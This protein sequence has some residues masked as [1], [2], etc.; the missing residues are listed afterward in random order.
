MNALHTRP[1]AMPALYL[2]LTCAVSA[3]TPTIRAIS[4]L[5]G[6]S[7]QVA[8]G[9]VFIIAGTDL[10]RAL[11]GL[12]Q[13][14][15]LTVTVGGKTALIRSYQPTNIESVLPYEVPLG[16]QPVVITSNGATVANGTVQ[17]ARLAPNL[18]TDDWSRAGRGM[19]VRPYVA[20]DM[21]PNGS[22]LIQYPRASAAE[23]AVPGENVFV[24]VTGLGATNPASESLK[25]PAKPVPF[26][27]AVRLTAGGRQMENVRAVLDPEHEMPLFREVSRFT[28]TLGLGRV[29]F[30][31]P[32]DMAEGTHTL[33]IAA[34]GV[35]GN[36]VQLFVGKARPYI[37]SVFTSPGRFSLA[38]SPG[39]LLSL[40]GL[41][42]GGKSAEG[43]FTSFKAGDVTVEMDGRP[44]PILGV[45][46][47]QGQIN[48][49]TPMDLPVNRRVIITLRTPQGTMN[50]PVFSY[51]VLPSLFKL[52]EPAPPNRAFAIA[53][54]ANTAWLPLPASAADALKL[55]K[56]CVANEINVLSTCA[57]PVKAGDIL[58][59][60][61]TGLGLATSDGTESGIKLAN[62]T[63]APADGSVLHRLV[64]P[65]AVTVGG[66][67][68]ETVF[69]GLAPGYAGLYQINIRIP[70]AAPPGRCRGARN[71]RPDRNPKHFRPRD[72]LHRRTVTPADANRLSRGAY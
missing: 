10:S 4:D 2:L 28:S 19:V 1:A 17:I 39:A 21:Q 35:E 16:A 41:H 38:T 52:T 54:L 59:V 30:T 33:T 57:A 32:K 43:G 7:T 51:P 34:N 40:Y 3:Q 60:Y 29:Y 15:T 64:T 62:G 65:L 31:I 27:A 47:P 56:D 20:P 42:F 68:A 70:A 69:A 55:P 71:H 12:G 5:Q 23:P 67:F 26:A 9:D 11:S 44:I 58:Q 6:R 46:E 36:P 14:A 72:D 53:T 61:A 45:Y 24:M 49:V 48:V 25:Y 50:Y 37:T 22:I 66:V 8:P 18:L 13:P 63:V